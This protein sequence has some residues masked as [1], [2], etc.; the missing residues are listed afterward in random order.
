MSTP[1]SGVTL[2]VP[3][4]FLDASRQTASGA[5]GLPAASNMDPVVFAD[6][7]TADA[8]DTEYDGFHEEVS[9][10]FCTTDAWSTSAGK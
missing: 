9:T 10:E 5:A 7:E 1:A 2:G 8:L 3:P 6:D 4:G